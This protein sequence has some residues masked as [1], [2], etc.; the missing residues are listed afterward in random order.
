M[1]IAT[2]GRTLQKPS[3]VFATVR[4]AKVDFA[5]LRPMHGK[6]SLFEIKTYG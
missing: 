6:K 5:N 4:L 3:W 2:L 1:R